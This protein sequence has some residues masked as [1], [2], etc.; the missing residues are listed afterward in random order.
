VQH[1]CTYLLP[2]N[3]LVSL[4]SALPPAVVP[5]VLFIFFT[6]IVT[7]SAAMSTS[8]GVVHRPVEKRTVPIARSSSTPIAVSTELTWIVPA[9]Q[10]EPADA[11][12]RS[13]ILCS[14]EAA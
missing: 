11:A 6:S 5:Y 4:L 9:W 8:S 13:P 1:F 7:T 2:V 12:T 14:S 3:D 10:A